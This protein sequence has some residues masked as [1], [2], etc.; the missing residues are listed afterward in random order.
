MKLQIL[1]LNKKNNMK[2]VKKYNNI[3][4]SE[5]TWDIIDLFVWDNNLSTNSTILKLIT[6]MVYWESNINNFYKFLD[7]NLLSVIDIDNWDIDIKKLNNNDLDT[8]YFTKIMLEN[9]WKI[10]IKWS[11]ISWTQLPLKEQWYIYVE[12]DYNIISIVKYNDIIKS[13]NW[14]PPFFLVDTYKFINNADSI[15]IQN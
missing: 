4:L 10:S 13:I 7:D 5:L 2:I 1:L 6:K 11:K 14:E 15:V 12:E 8:Y 3:I 9:F